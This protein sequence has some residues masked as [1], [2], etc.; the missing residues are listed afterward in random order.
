MSLLAIPKEYKVNKKKHFDPLKISCPP[1]DNISTAEYTMVGNFP[2][3]IE[4]MEK[5]PFQG[6]TGNQLRRI[7]AAVNL[8]LYKVYLTLACK[9]LV[10]GN[11]SNLL[12]TQKG[13]RHPL[14]ST[15][16]LMLINELKKF[17]GK[18]IILLGNVAMQLLLDEA[19]FDSINKYR[20]SIYKAEEFPH[21]AEVLKGKYIAITYHP[22][23]TL[24]NKNP[25]HFY[26][27]IMDF[28]KFIKFNEDPKVL[29]DL[30]EIKI[31]PL[32][33]EIKLHFQNCLK[34]KLIGF[35]IECTP[36]FITC[37]SLAYLN[38]D[39]IISMSIP[40]ID[41]K[42]NYWSIHD[43]ITIW[44]GLAKILFHPK[45]RIV[46]QN[47]M[48]DLMFLLRTMNIISDN[49]YFD[50]MIAQ[51][52]VYTDLPKGL[53][54][55]TS[56]YT[57]YPYYKDEGKQSHLSIIKDW[58][59]YWIYNAKDSAYLLKI[60][61]KLQEELKDFN[62]EEAMQY[63]MELHKPLM[64]ME[65]NGI[66]TDRVG[67]AKAKKRYELK[68]KSMETWLKRKT[69]KD[70]N[71]NSSKQMIAYFYGTCMIKPYLQRTGKGKGNA[72]CNAVALSRIARKKVRGS[73]EAK[74]IIKIRQ[75][76]KLVSTYFTINVDKD[77]KLRCSHKITGT[78]Y[79]RISTE[80][81]FFG[82]GAN[83]Q[84]QPYEYKKYLIPD[85][86]KIICEVDLAKAEAH[87]VAFLCQDAN[88]IEAFKSGIDVH[89][90]NASKIFN[91][92]IEEVIKEAKEKKVD[93]KKTKRYMGK[94]VVHASN[95]GMG[96]QTFSDNL[97]KENIFMSM[98]EC[99]T[100]L[101]NYQR[102]FPGLSRWHE[103]IKQ[104]VLQKRILYNLFNRP[105]R[106]LGLMNNN[107]FM[108]A[109]S[110]KPQSTVAELL[111]RGSIKICNDKRLN[112]NHYDIELLATVHDSDVFQFHIKNV[113]NLLDILLIIND[114]MKHT[115]TYKGRSF[116]IGLDA[117][118]GFQWAGDKTAEISSFT[119]ENVENALHK[120]GVK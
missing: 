15:L 46:C 24:V 39:K 118:I 79:G 36:K 88:M 108:S 76:K 115:F 105:V 84:N 63:S 7:C 13:Y 40:L 6:P 90:F 95:Y 47:G 113:P 34:A 92:S 75:Y 28:K 35:D 102:R 65:Y 120:I 106:F 54:F 49:F 37:F 43:E 104:E 58:K 109:Y 107:T 1:T 67:I 117:K 48:F 33:S 69:G 25:V 29:D 5:E 111:N 119:K 72:T 64:E 30:P 56:I 45:V 74:I 101:N 17:P 11:N 91:V 61:P 71:I 21:L 8:P 55:L 20:G 4:V 82:T 81:T 10:P 22:S 52:L 16:Q 99:R 62:A 89:S 98:S 80:H 114:H 112:R 53:D 14:W 70:L 42:G 78:K 100:L 110:F 97:A 12:F 116:T 93:Q 26:T 3:S 38:K 50:T 60:M 32:L 73:D 41:N 94:K 57:Y 23:F 19:K 96:P 2:S 31:K 87:V 86:D 27:M 103:L 44:E 68:I 83:L 85:K 51:H 77:N 18:L 59:S 9:A 66:L